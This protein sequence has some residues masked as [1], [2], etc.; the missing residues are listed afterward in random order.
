MLTSCNS[1]SSDD[2]INLTPNIQ[3]TEEAYKSEWVDNYGNQLFFSTYP[4]NLPTIFTL[5][6]DPAYFGLTGDSPDSRMFPD[7]YDFSIDSFLAY[8]VI[9]NNGLIMFY[10]RANRA[11][12]G[13]D[14]ETSNPNYGWRTAWT[15]FPK[16]SFNLSDHPIS[17]RAPFYNYYRRANEYFDSV[18]LNSLKFVSD[19][20]YNYNYELGSDYTLPKSIPAQTGVCQFQLVK[21]EFFKEG[22]GENT[23]TRGN[24]QFSL[25]ILRTFR[26]VSRT[27][28][29]RPRLRSTRQQF[30]RMLD[31]VQ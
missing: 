17:L 22:E 4:Y 13:L 8:Q 12:V 19:Y 5:M 26:L 2:A 29:K 16:C 7:D 3:I 27:K 18:N 28:L 25:S 11:T 31:D 20:H 30:L 6:P 14:E 15:Y 10:G 9:N 24:A 21:N 23:L 1:R